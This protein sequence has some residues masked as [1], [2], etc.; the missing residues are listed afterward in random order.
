MAKLTS[1]TLADDLL[2]RAGPIA[3]YI[4][5]EDTRKTRRQVYYQFERRKK[6]GKGAPIFG[7]GV[8]LTARKSEL[9]RHYSADRD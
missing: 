1:P 2:R 9:D 4:F 8:T 6:T 7:D 3:L 5:G